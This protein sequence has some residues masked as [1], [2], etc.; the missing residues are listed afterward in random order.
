MLIYRKSPPICPYCHTL[1]RVRKHGTSLCG[2]QR[3]RCSECQRTFQG[4]YIYQMYRQTPPV[5]GI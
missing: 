4:K 2:F 5:T 1:T 3:Y